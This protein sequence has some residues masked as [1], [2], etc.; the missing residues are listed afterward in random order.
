MDEVIISTRLSAP[1]IRENLVPRSQPVKKIELGAK[2]CLKLALVSAPA[3]YGKTTLVAKWL[4]KSHDTYAWLSLDSSN[5]ELDSFY[6]YL[7]A[8][9]QNIDK[10]IGSD[11]KKLLESIQFIYPETVAISLI[12]DINALSI[13]CILVLDNY[14]VIKSDFIHRVVEFI[15]DNS[16]PFLYTVV[17]SRHVPPFSLSKWRAKNQIIEI[18]IDDLKFDAKET[19]RFLKKTM[20]LQLSDPQISSLNDKTEG[21]AAGLQLAALFLKG[22]ERN[23]VEET[24]NGFNG[25]HNF[26]VEYFFENVFQSQSV[27][28]KQFLRNTSILDQL[29]APL[30]NELVNRKDSQS[31]LEH[32]VED[33]LFLEPLDIENKW[34]RCHQ[35]FRDYLQTQLDSKEKIRL[36]KIAAKWLI[37]NGYYLQAIEHALA[38]KDTENAVQLI[39]EQLVPLITNYKIDKVINWLDELSDTIVFNNSLFCTYKACAYFLNSDIQKAKYYVNAMIT[40]PEQDDLNTGRIKAVK[41]MV[42]DDREESIRLATDA[43]ELIGDEDPFVSLISLTSLARAQRDIGDLDQS[44]STLNKALLICSRVGYHMPIYN[45]YLDLAF[46]YYI[47]GNLQQAIQFCQSVINEENSINGECSPVIDLMNIP[48]GVFYLETNDLQ[49]AEKCIEK[50]L[51]AAN[52]L[53]IQKTLGGDA[54]MALARIRFLQGKS[55]EAISILHQCIHDELEA[56]L[57]VA[58]LRLSATLAEIQLKLG[59]T[60]WVEDWVKDSNL[61]LDAKISSPKELPYLVYARLLIAEERWSEAEYLLEKMENISRASKR[62]GRLV[63]ILTLKSLLYSEQGLTFKAKGI[64]IEA[65]NLAASQNF[66]RPFLNEGDKLINLLSMVEDKAPDFVNRIITEYTKEKNKEVLLIEQG[67]F[68]NSDLINTGSGI[69]EPLSDRELDVL[70]LVAEGL[71]NN[72]ISHRLHISLGTVKWYLYQ[73]FN[74]LEVKNR[75]QAVIRAKDLNI[76]G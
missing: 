7:I 59:N 62:K 54:E 53:G 15:I 36:H 31:F 73:I 6:S 55:G 39:S 25:S 8:A 1:K 20:D 75:M 3:G 69:F 52:R 66:Y 4:E 50:G 43:L 37:D 68:T 24:I 48:L 76:F 72:Q 5:N 11:S 42:A 22:Q 17:I 10:S 34:F 46:N 65:I 12:N 23:R 70:N 14:H 45:I 47:H 19:E 64:L 58:V 38:G 35:L 63:K 44:T 33:N 61:S 13:P 26:V 30:C 56:G 57:K 18:G 16:P 9:F 49:S 67:G 40:S 2:S 29:Y 27:E 32:L 74:K 71:S 41:S 28:M 60:I 21:W 51:E